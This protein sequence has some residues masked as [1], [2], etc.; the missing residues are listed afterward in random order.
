M[1]AP[2]GQ[3]G[4]EKKGRE[5]RSE[6]QG[7]EGKG[8]PFN[9]TYQVKCPLLP[10]GEVGEG[11]EKLRVLLQERERKF[12]LQGSELPADAEPWALRFMEGSREAALP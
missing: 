7:G 3:H 12:P 6:R 4:P 1:N 11:P 8:L 9:L 2:S 5:R 10:W